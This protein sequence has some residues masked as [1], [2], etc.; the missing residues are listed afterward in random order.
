MITNDDLDAIAT[1]TMGD[2]YRGEG[3]EVAP[4]RCVDC[5]WRDRGATLA[6]AHQ[7]ATGHAVRGKNWPASWP[8][9]AEPS[10]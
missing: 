7:R 8:N 10:K 9:L 1:W 2:G 6:Y 5:T 4:Y 3:G